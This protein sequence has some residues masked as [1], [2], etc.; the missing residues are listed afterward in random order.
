MMVDGSS[1][2]YVVGYN[3]QIASAG[4]PQVIVAQ[5]VVQEPNDANS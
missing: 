5:S 1:K 3:A 2:A 4:V